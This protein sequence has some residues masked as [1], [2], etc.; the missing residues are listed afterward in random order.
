MRIHTDNITLRDVFEAARIAGVEFGR[1]DQKGSRS[2]ARAFDVTLRGDSNRR[3]NH[4]TSRSADRFDCGEYAATW[5]QWGVFLSVLF[6][7][8]PLAFTPYDADRASFHERT[9]DR[10]QA[11]GIL[12]GRPTR[13]QRNDPTCPLFGAIRVPQYASLVDQN[14]ATG[15]VW[16]L[17]GS[18]WPAD[19]HGDHR[20]EF[21]APFVQ[22]CSKCSATARY[23]VPRRSAS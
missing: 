20:F 4:G 7:L 5:D 16:R 9:A 1:C 8:D 15:Y 6:D 11:S 14:V 3:P 12:G 18:Y 22:K 23:D 17:R 19:A 21:E 2:R 10:F 13:Q